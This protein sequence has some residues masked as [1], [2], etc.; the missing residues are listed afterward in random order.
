MGVEGYH[1]PALGIIAGQGI[2]LVG[3]RHTH[4]RPLPVFGDGMQTR[5]LCYVDDLIE[6]ILRLL[7]S[8]YVGPVNLGNPDEITILQLAE[9]IQAAS[10]NSPGIG[11]PSPSTR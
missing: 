8:D 3:N 10:G 9:V 2:S 4:N 6:G 1:M 7:A 5:S 11:V